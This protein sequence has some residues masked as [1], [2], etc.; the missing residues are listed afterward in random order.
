QDRAGIGPQRSGQQVEVG[1]LAGAV[2]A[3]DGV[4]QPAREGEA[5]VLR[6]GER[7]ERLLQRAGLERRH[8]SLSRGARSRAVRAARRSAASM[9]VPTIP[10][11]ISRATPANTRPRNRYQCANV[12][13]N[14]SFISTSSVAPSGAPTK[15]PMPPMTTAIKTSPETNQLT[16]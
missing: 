10:F 9:R 3:D 15:V 5:H 6:H 8:A 11:G 13:E 4:A 14:S 1:G 16:S 12:D 7:A 2:R